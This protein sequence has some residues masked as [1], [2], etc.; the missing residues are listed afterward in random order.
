[1]LRTL[2]SDTT[3]L[4]IAHRLETIMDYD[5]VLV[6]SNGRAAEFGTPMDLF[7]RNGIFTDLVNATGEGAA[8]LISIAKE[9]AYK[10]RRR[11]NLRQDR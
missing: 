3:L 8:S 6:L 5:K 7:E 1:M 11:I 10:R 4:T 9:A 2:F